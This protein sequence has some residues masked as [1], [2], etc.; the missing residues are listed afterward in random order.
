M[1]WAAGEYP[2]DKLKKSLTTLLFDSINS[3]IC[4]YLKIH[5]GHTHTHSTLSCNLKL[6]PH[7]KIT[8]F[9]VKCTYF[10]SKWCLIFTEFSFVIQNN[11]LVKCA[12]L[13][14]FGCCLSFFVQPSH[15]L[16]NKIREN[17]C[18][19]HFRFTIKQG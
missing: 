6:K 7:T 17:K 5:I 19:L 18:W 10:I 9:F 12:H 13:I 14:R 16:T 15:V 2:N 1:F 4:T 11:G 3:E 8:S